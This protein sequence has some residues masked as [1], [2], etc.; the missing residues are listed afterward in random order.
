MSQLTSFSPPANWLDFGA[1]DP[2]HA[3][4]NA[5]WTANINRWTQVAIIGNPWA[6]QNDAPRPFYFNPLATDVPAN[7]QTALITWNAFPGRLAAYFTGS[8]PGFPPGGPAST[9]TL[10]QWA[11]TGAIP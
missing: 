4:L 5:A 7:P 10:Q 9:T 3:L 8:F 11:D 2:N 1:T 6:N